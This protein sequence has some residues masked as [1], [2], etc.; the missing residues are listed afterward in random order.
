VHLDPP[1][2]EMLIQLIRMASR[3]E[4]NTTPSGGLPPS[5]IF[6]FAGK[7]LMAL[8]EYGPAGELRRKIY[9]DC[10]SDIKQMKSSATGS[11]NVIQAFLRMSHL[12]I[13]NLID[14]TIIRT[15]TS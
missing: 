12:R 14:L 4:E 1:P 7:E 10:I 11:I 3:E 5:T 15:K 8:A 13:I 6:E 9:L 2:Y